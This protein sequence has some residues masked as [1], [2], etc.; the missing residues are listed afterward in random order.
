M[1]STKNKG[2]DFMDSSK[3]SLRDFVYIPDADIMERASIFEYMDDVRKNTTINI[4]SLS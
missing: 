2:S 4:A 3:Y 1:L